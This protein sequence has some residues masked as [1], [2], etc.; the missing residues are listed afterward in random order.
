[1]QITPVQTICSTAMILFSL[2][3]PQR[4]VVWK[5][6]VGKRFKER[7][8]GLRRGMQCGGTRVQD[9]AGELGGKGVI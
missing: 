8:Q 1:M 7:G 4:T 9:L 2:V 3:E 6:R 5:N